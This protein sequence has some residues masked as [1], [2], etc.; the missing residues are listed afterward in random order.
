M[1][2]GGVEFSKKPETFS[3]LRRALPLLNF[4]A[5]PLFGA[6]GEGKAP[7]RS[8]SPP[9]ASFGGAAAPAKEFPAPNLPIQNPFVWLI[10]TEFRTIDVISNEK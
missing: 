3:R 9:G 5:T 6:L 10:I 1:V 4:P 2:C 7:P 8:S